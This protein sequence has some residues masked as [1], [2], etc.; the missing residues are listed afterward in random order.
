MTVSHAVEQ[1]E[2]VVLK[3][4]NADGVQLKATNLSVEG[5]TGAYRK[6]K[7]IFKPLRANG[8]PSGHQISTVV[9]IADLDYVYDLFGNESRDQSYAERYLER[10]KFLKSIGIPVISSMR[11]VDD[12][13]VLMGNMMVDGGQFIGKDTYWWS[14]S[15]KWKRDETGHLTEEEKLFLNI[16]PTLIKQEVKR[17]FD[18]AW[19]NGVLLPDSDE[20]F[21]VLVKPTG[22]WRVLVKD[23]GTLRRIPESMKNDHTRDSLRK[24]LADRVDEIRKE[25][26]KHEKHV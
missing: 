15:S 19:K 23:L 18:I 26:S 20:E 13:R 1:G 2:I 3:K 8:E 16:D 14:E 22:E 4:G 17:I 5:L 21:T 11:V 6:S 24:E 10:W 9:K 25:L 12:D 7:A